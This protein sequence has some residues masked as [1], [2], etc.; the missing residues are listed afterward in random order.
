MVIY[1]RAG[2]QSQSQHPGLRGRSLAF[3][4]KKWRD[5]NRLQ[6]GGLEDLE[7]NGQIV[8]DG[9]FNILYGGWMPN[10]DTGTHSQ[11]QINSVHLLLC[12]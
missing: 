4:Q 2:W 9:E 1:R 8:Q 6:K 11:C 10:S 3:A 12:P 7:D 5:W